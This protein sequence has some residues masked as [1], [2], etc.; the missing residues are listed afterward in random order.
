M[1]QDIEVLF[2]LLFVEKNYLVKK[3]RELELSSIICLKINY[4]K[5]KNEQNNIEAQKMSINSH[6]YQK[7]HDQLKKNNSFFVYVYLLKF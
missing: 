4:V 5:I 7:L 2:F 6:I 1:D 3:F